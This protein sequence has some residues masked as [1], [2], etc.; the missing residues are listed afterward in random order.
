MAGEN[1]E[2]YSKIVTSGA[3]KPCNTNQDDQGRFVALI[4]GA[5][6]KLLDF[7]RIS[8]IKA[9]SNFDRPPPQLTAYQNRYSVREGATEPGLN[10]AWKVIGLA[11]D[12][13][14]SNWDGEFAMGV[15][16]P[17]YIGD[18]KGSLGCVPPFARKSSA[19]PGSVQGT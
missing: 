6:H 15:A 8:H 5:K 7:G 3:A 14:L 13:I 9:F 10:N 17:N 16:P 19:V 18:A 4:E 11:I 2:Y 12:D 1:V